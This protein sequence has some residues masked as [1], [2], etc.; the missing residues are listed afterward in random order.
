MQ[1]LVNDPT[2]ALTTGRPAIRMGATEW[3][4]I[5]LHSI[6]WG[7]AYFFG[8][9][10]I[11]E[12][13]PLTVTA[14]RLI[15]ACL[16][17][18]G[19]CLAVGN[20]IP[21]TA[22]Y[23]RRSFVLGL[24][25]NMLPM[26]L[27]L[28]AQAQVT[29]GVAAVFNATSPLF[30]VVLAHFVTADERLTSRT[31]AGIAAGILGVAVL[32]GTDVTSGATGGALAKVALLAAAGC[33]A[34][35]GVYARRF[36]EPPFVIASGQMLSA[37]VLAMPIALLVDQ[38]WQIAAPSPGAMAAVLAMGT[39]GSAFA[40]LLYF[41]VL[42]RAGATNTLLVTLLLPLTPIVLG[43]IF[44]GDELHAREI[45]GAALIGLALVILDGR[46][47]QRLAGR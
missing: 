10:A 4:L 37:L 3:A 16:I 31:V 2:G 12:L 25:N 29:G 44:L 32:V 11:R 17:V 23:W 26:L 14:F 36:P 46:V 5:V 43:A 22:D 18:V 20:R 34:I 38:P 13:P 41:T 28:W 45:A 42:R 1:R 33:Y 24:F 21:M 19:V 35:S 8:A 27:I 15:P 9:I 6:M 40:A 7:S 47:W 39:F 30:A